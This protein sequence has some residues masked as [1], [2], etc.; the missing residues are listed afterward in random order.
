MLSEA[1]IRAAIPAALDAVELPGWGARTAGKVRDIY[2]AADRVLLVAT[3]RV[4]A[5]DR[6]LGLVPFKGQVLNE[7]SAWWFAATRDIVANHLLA[8]P[9]P[10]VTLARAATV[11]PVEVVV[12]GYLT[13]ITSTAIWTLYAAGERAPYG[14]PLPDGLRR[15]DPLPAPIITPTS[16]ADDGGHDRPL[17][18]AAIVDGGLVAGGVWAAVEQT[19]LA[20]FARGQ[21]VAREAGLILV[22]TKY[23]FGLLDGQLLLVDE[24]H[25]PDS[26]RYWTAASYGGGQEPENYDK[27]VLRKWLAAA[28]YAGDGPPPA[29]SDAIV[30]RLATLYIA[31]YERLTGQAFVPGA[32][33]ARERIIHNVAA[34]RDVDPAARPQ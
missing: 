34:V 8:V 21:A 31:A 19:A 16:K 24:I 32:Q 30:T 4:S 22:D 26:S 1:A 20:L 6:V 13:G 10:N 27:E 11:L 29:L 12:R 25:T 23:E 7:L 9:D 17:T 5:F 15:H 28:N 2:R 33:P 18:R 14:V 3:D